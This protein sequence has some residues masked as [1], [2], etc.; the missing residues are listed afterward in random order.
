[1]LI[2]SRR[3]GQKIHIGNDITVT[4]L[5]FWKQDGKYIR[6]GIEAPDDVVILR[7]EVR[8]RRLAGEEPKDE[9]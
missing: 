6:L 3:V 9:S 2:L 7:E 8:D 4:V 5:E 1:M